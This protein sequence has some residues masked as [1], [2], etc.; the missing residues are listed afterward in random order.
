MSAEPIC[1]GCEIKAEL[2]SRERS[3]EEEYAAWDT[4]LKLN[5][6]QARLCRDSMERFRSCREASDLP[7]GPS[8]LPPPPRS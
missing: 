4:C 6:G 1:E 2:P 8:P 3:C 7:A 5:S